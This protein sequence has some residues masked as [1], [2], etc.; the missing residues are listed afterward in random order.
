MNQRTKLLFALMQIEGII[1]L[2]KGNEYEAFFTSHLSPV[3]YELQ[4][5]LTNQTNSTKMKE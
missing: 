5:Q 1:K 4:R 2:M 3:I